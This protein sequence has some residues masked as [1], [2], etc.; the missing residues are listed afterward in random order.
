MSGVL[1]E[2]ELVRIENQRNLRTFATVFE[3]NF[4]RLL[5]SAMQRLKDCI[6]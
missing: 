6:T 5:L 1:S 4:K 3:N 2:K